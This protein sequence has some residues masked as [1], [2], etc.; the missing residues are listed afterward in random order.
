METRKYKAQIKYN[1][2][3]ENTQLILPKD[4]NPHQE[5]KRLGGPGTTILRVKRV[6]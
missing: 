5:F 6:R 4:R 1:D 3:I 2:R